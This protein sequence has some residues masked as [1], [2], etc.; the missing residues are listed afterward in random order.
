MSLAKLLALQGQL[1]VFQGH[2][3][4]ALE[5]VGVL[6]RLAKMY[7]LEPGM[8][9][10][11][12]A[13]ADLSLGFTSI[14]QGLIE[15]LW[16]EAQ[17]DQLQLWLAKIDIP[18]AFVR[19]IRSERAFG[20]TFESALRQRFRSP[21]RFGDLVPPDARA[22]PI[23]WALR[24]F[25]VISLAYQEA[26]EEASP[27]EPFGTRIA[28]FNKII[29]RLQNSPATEWIAGY[30]AIKMTGI[31]DAFLEASRRLAVLRG[32]TQIE[33]FRLREGNLP[34]ALTELPNLPR[35]PLTNLPLGYHVADGTFVL[36]ASD[37][38]HDDSPFTFR[39]ESAPH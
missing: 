23:G 12:L 19:G 33:R 17:L 8:I 22:F 9:F 15:Q 10:Q 18:A 20:L 1:D 7:M 24:G 30:G 32:A 37:R 16:T 26:I 25:G 27:E 14:E 34:K 35:D 31:G 39:S 11:V 2:G 5:D 28:T 21:A 4:K 29:G 3:T 38:D 6:L 13:L 36:E